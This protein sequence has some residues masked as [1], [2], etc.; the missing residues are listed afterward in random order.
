MGLRMHRAPSRARTVLRFAT[1][2]LLLL[3]LALVGLSLIRWQSTLNWLGNFLVCSDRPEPADLILVMGGDFWG[4]RVLKAAQL[5]AQGWAPLVLISGPPYGGRPEGELA[6]ELMVKQGYPHNL[7][8]VFPHDQASTLGEV[9]ALRPELARRGARRVIVVTSSYH[10]RRCAILFR[11]FCPGIRFVSAP[12]P[13][14]HYQADDW[15]KDPSSH[16]LFFSE[17]NKIL[18]SVLVSYPSY[19][20]TH[21]GRPGS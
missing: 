4:P 13:D 17:W 3:T 2:T 20:M 21:W 19:W 6:V 12:A 8:A 15:W 1:R 10:S 7:F 18:G 11:L 9:L 14:S 5:G 16:E